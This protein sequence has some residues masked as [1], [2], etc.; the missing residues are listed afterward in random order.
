MDREMAGR[1]FMKAS[2]EEGARGVRVFP[3]YG[4]SDT[5]AR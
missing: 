3:D 2:E 1:L 5:T 4:K